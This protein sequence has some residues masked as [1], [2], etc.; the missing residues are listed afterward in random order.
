MT[1]VTAFLMKLLNFMHKPVQQQGSFSGSNMRPQQGCWNMQG[2][3]NE[4]RGGTQPSPQDLGFC[5]LSWVTRTPQ[6]AAAAPKVFSWSIYESRCQL[7]L[8]NPK[9]PQTPK[10][11][12]TT[13]ISGTQPRC[14]PSPATPDG[15]L[16]KPRILLRAEPGH[17][18]SPL[19]GAVR[20]ML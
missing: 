19:L 11:P 1:S 10:T 18:P 15:A 17:N 6:A 7:A 14:L 5:L 9:T 13:I 4:P 8:Q 3:P 20:G 12:D 16:R 2:A